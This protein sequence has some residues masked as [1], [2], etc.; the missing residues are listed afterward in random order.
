LLKPFNTAQNGIDDVL[1]SIQR[2]DIGTDTFY[3]VAMA[4]TAGGVGEDLVY[5]NWYDTLY[6]IHWSVR[7]RRSVFNVPIQ[8]C[9]NSSSISDR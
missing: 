2:Y 1:I 5:L 3:T 6:K 9:R 8:S 4:K 7:W